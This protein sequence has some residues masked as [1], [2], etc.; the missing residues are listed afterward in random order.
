MTE[1]SSLTVGARLDKFVDVYLWLRGAAQE[2][3]LSRSKLHLK[4]VHPFADALTIVDVSTP[5]FWRIRLSGTKTCEREGKDKTGTNALHSFAESERALRRTLAYSLFDGP[6]GMR[7]TTRETYT[8]GAY[9]LLDTVALPM[10]GE[11]GQRLVVHYAQVMKDIEHQYRRRPLAK[12]TE[13]VSY[14]YVDLGHGVP[15][16]DDMRLTA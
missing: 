8:N 5:D 1:F 16:A 6:F 12:K 13:L 15:R 3:I 14:S 9:C 10:R 2:N 7:S 4:A 11:D